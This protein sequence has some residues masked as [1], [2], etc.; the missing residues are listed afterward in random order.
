[1]LSEPRPLASGDAVEDF[2]SGVS[3]LDEWLR[4]R[5]LANQVSGASR[6][7]VVLSGNRIAGYYCLAS[8][9]IGL[10]EAPSGLRRNMPD[11]LP[12]VV[13]GRLAVDVAWQKTGL[14]VALLKDSVLRAGQAATIIGI[15]AMLVHALSEDARTFYL[16]HGFTESPHDPRTLMLS[17]KR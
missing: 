10:N 12:V 2:S 8:G 14:G 16:R 1:V 5:A 9:G 17:L 13:L 3:A 7:Y 11:P 6:T 4:R 15:R